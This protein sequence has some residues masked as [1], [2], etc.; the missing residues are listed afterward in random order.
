M[1]YF[2]CWYRTI[3]D[4][5]SWDIYHFEYVIINN[6]NN[7]NNDNNDNNSTICQEHRDSFESGSESED[8]KGVDVSF[9]AR[10]AEIKVW[11]EKGD[12]SIHS[13]SRDRSGHRQATNSG[14]AGEAVIVLVDAMK[15]NEASETGEEDNYYLSLLQPCTLDKLKSGK[16]GERISSA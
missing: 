16:H 8:H 15:R 4:V 1:T 7:K 11:R 3:N 6:K 13:V 14:T 5:V 9:N 2:P 12:G 10:A